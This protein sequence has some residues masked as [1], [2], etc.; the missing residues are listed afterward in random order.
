MQVPWMLDNA[1]RLWAC[2]SGR[3]FSGSFAFLHVLP[4][5]CTVLG[6]GFELGLESGVASG[7]GVRLL[8]YFAHTVASS[9]TRLAGLRGDSGG[10]ASF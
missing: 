5:L 4:L 6:L 1:I 3:S 8:L 7:L 9:E 2:L 10:Y